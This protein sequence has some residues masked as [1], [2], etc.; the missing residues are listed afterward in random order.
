MYIESRKA[1]YA[2]RGK[3]LKTHILWSDRGP[4][5]F[6]TAPFIVYAIDI[7][8][9]NDVNLSMN[10]TTTGHGKHVH[11]AIIGHSKG[12]ARNGFKN[13]LSRIQSGESIAGATCRW[14][15]S[16]LGGDVEKEF[17]EIPAEEVRVATSPVPRI[18]TVEKKGIK[19]YHGSCADTNGNVKFRR[20]SCHCTLCVSSGFDKCS[21]GIF[22]G[23][24]VDC[25]IKAHP[26]YDTIPTKSNPRKRRRICN[27][28][29]Q[30]DR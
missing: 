12:K 16:E 10:T 21:K 15:K 8:N 25:V 1:E 13:N 11:D 4:T 22:A 5:D 30:N 2:S 20:L 14:L 28:S 23:D 9:D 18:L 19:T 27:V 7:C 29:N 3:T 26:E 17:I 6:W 24:W